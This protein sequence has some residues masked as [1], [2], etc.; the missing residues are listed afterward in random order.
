MTL[1]HFEEKLKAVLLLLCSGGFPSGIPENAFA[2]IR[3]GVQQEQE[4]PIDTGIEV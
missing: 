3:H 2:R 4:P 1:E